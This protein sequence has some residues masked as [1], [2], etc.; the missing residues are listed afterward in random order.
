MSAKALPA[1]GEAFL[2]ND[3]GA[4]RV[5][6]V[7]LGAAAANDVVCAAQAT[8][9]LFDVA[10]GVV[11]DN[12]RYVVSTAFSTSVTMTI[13]DTD[14]DGFLTSVNIAP[15]VG[16]STGILKT[17][18]AAAY[19]GGKWYSAADA[20]NAVIAGASPAAGRIELFFYWHQEGDTVSP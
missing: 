17:L 20:I 9:K 8:Y 3:P 15:T 19:A 18:V 6:K 10:A 5:T 16:V 11:I 13:G 4:M 12:I 7:T 14:A 1:V 2:G